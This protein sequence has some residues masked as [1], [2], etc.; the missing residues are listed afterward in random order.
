MMVPFPT[1]NQCLDFIDQFEM[2]DNIRA[3]SFKVAR[4]AELIIGRLR[5]AG[6]T[7]S[8]LAAGELVIAGALLHDIAKTECLKTGCM[9]ADRG[10]EICR[11]LGYPEIGEIVR[12]HVILQEFR[13]ELYQQGL[14]GAKELV[15]YA[16]KRVRHDEIVSLDS[17]LD[18]IIE[19]YGN[20]DPKR[21]HYIRLNFQQAQELEVYLFNFLDFSADQVSPLISH[22]PFSRT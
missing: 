2:L 22:E 15:C 9:H 13:A 16:D 14:F 19:R 12:E 11:D 4:V 3:H 21:E 10:D 7:K 6:K 17:R 1:V 8:S 18:Y 5:E 20:S